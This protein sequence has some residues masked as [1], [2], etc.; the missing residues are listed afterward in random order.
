MNY[1]RACGGLRSKAGPSPLPVEW[2]MKLSL[3]ACFQKKADRRVC[4]LRSSKPRPAL[5][6][7]EKRRFLKLRVF[8][9]CLGLCHRPW[10]SGNLKW[11]VLRAPEECSETPSPS[12]ASA[13]RLALIPRWV[14]CKCP[15]DRYRTSV[16]LV[17]TI[18]ALND[19][20]VFWY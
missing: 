19:Q 10:G 16:L 2:V 3:A 6:L 12:P 11:A 20:K 14:H 15:H 5:A 4:R 1:S 8:S 17:V 9:G 13:Q 7:K 18:R